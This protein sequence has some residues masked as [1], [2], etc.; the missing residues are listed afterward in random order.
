MHNSV[1]LFVILLC[2]THVACLFVCLLFACLL[3]CFCKCSG[4]S[5][6]YILYQVLLFSMKFGFHFHFSRHIR[7][8]EV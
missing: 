1:I 3:A 4:N 6:L 8:S 5:Y 2:M 7:V